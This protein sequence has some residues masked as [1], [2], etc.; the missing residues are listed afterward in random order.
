MED[1]PMGGINHQPCRK[2]LG[3]STR[4]SRALSL[5]RAQLEQANVFL[6]D[7]LLM[8]LDPEMRGEQGLHDVSFY[9]VN[10]RHA[11]VSLQSVTGALQSFMAECDHIDLFKVMNIHPM[12]V[13]LDLAT[14][15]LARRDQLVAAAAKMHESG[16]HAVLA[17]FHATANTLIVKTDRLLAKVH[18]LQQQQR[19]AEHF[20]LTSVLE[21]NL[22]GNF[23]IE[24][25]QL[26]DG[27]NEFQAYF[28]ASAMISTEVWYRHSNV[29]SLRTGP[30]PAVAVA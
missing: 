5:G 14:A 22:P 7:T 20:S 3:F 27:W 24:F 2:F 8:E 12:Q 9:L 28:L 30:Q 10:S 29:G 25:A 17:E 19:N 13:A 23:K 21:E 16:F 18:E 6:E 15:N 11:L 26:Y 4:M 1:P